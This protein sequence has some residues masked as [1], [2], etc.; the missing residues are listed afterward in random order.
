MTAPTRH[1]PAAA[2][3]SRPAFGP[4]NGGPL[5]AAAPHALPAPNGRVATPAAPAPAIASEIAA[6]SGLVS[7]AVQRAA[8]MPQAAL[9]QG[10]QGR[11]QVGFVYVDGS[12]EGIALL[13]S[14]QS[15]WLDEAAL[16][17]VRSAHY[18]ASPPSLRSLRIPM[19]VW[20]DFELRLAAS[21]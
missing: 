9:R 11:A 19:Q 5:A 3:P 12:A 2:Q 20:V 7:T 17:A 1:M 4:A 14:S 18:P 21:T 6:L 13:Q 16:G 15:R 8:V 10:R